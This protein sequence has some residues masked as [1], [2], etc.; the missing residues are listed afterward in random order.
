MDST[1]SA[2]TLGCSRR[3][4]SSASAPFLDNAPGDLLSAMARTNLRVGQRA[5][6][7]DQL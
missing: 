7:E 3:V 5:D 2:L 1:V 4:K 6:R